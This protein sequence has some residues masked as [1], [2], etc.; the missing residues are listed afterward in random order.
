M[1]DRTNGYAANVSVPSPL[2]SLHGIIPTADAHGDIY[3]IMVR[4]WSHANHRFGVLYG[5][6]HRVFAAGCKAQ[7]GKEALLKLLEASHAITG[8][9]Y[10]I[11]A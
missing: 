2:V 4:R 8:K 1:S 11:L 5:P 9:V 7:T 3:N 10:A 6:V